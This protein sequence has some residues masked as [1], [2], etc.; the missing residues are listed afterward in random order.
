MP[1]F[2]AVRDI[3]FALV[4]RIAPVALV[5]RKVMLGEVIVPT[6][7]FLG[8]AV[9]LQVMVLFVVWS[10]GISCLLTLEVTFDIDASAMLLNI[11]LM[12]NSRPDRI[13]FFI[14]S[15]SWLRAEYCR[16]SKSRE[17]QEQ[18]FCHL[19]LCSIPDVLK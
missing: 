11:K 16:E 4:P 17:N 9:M 12:V 2:E 5:A 8:V 19:F 7:F 3:D 6:G 15:E 14:I 10:A 1:A 18:D 13:V